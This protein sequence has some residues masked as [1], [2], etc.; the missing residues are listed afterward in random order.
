MAVCA[1]SRRSASGLRE[2]EDWIAS[3]NVVSKDWIWAVMDGEGEVFGFR[4]LEGGGSERMGAGIVS[5]A[6]RSRMQTKF[7]DDRRDGF[8]KC[9]GST[10]TSRGAD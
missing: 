4:F 10:R 6:T 1:R 3:V 5:V 9:C 7:E 2:A 8:G